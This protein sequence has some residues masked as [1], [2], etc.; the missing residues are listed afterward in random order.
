MYL[1]W[2][3]WDKIKDEIARALRISVSEDKRGGENK[4]KK[5]EVW[6]EEGS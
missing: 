2:G 3:W 4:K 1:I 5:E 6:G